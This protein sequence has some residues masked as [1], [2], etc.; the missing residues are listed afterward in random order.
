[1]DFRDIL[2]RFLNPGA[3]VTDKAIVS[4]FWA[5]GINVTDRALQLG[6]MLIVARVLGPEEL[7][8]FGIG[9]L[10]LTGLR[11]LSQLG[12]SEALIQRAEENIDYLL[13]SAWTLELLRG[14]VLGLLAVL[15][16]PLIGGLLHEPRAVPLIQSMGLLPL[17]QGMTNPAAIYFQKDLSFHKEFLFRVSGSVSNF[18]VSATFAII[19]ETVWA[20]IA[21]LVASE[22][23]RLTASYA[24]DGYR[25][26]LRINRR[27]FAELM[28]YGKWIF[29]SSGLLF[30]IKNG[31]DA[32]L[33]GLLGPTALGLYQLSYRISNA[34]AT[35][36]ANVFNKVFFPTY[37]KFQSD[38]TQLRRGYF[39]GLKLISLCAFPISGGII[40]IAPAFVTIALGGQWSDSIILIQILGFF[41]LLRALGATDGPLIRA[42]GRP[43]I[44]TK[45]HLLQFCILGLIIFPFTNRY[46]VVGAS[47]AVVLSILPINIGK[48]IAVL[49]LVDGT[50]GRYVW[51][52]L[53]PAIATG[54][55][56]IAVHTTISYLHP[57]GALL[58][59]VPLGII[60]YTG[61]IVALDS[62]VDYGVRS[63]ISRMGET[64]GSEAN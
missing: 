58:I 15:A 31:D 35:E 56:M 1:M 51:I 61:G 38:N 18:S 40:V 12:I 10:V 33:A 3:N 17:L 22:L 14:I 24:L 62:T 7:G 4:G 48:S 46:G 43:D 44:A 25:P 55:M 45:F 63:L 64:F 19:Y 32:V 34:P 13:D 11:G 8:L 53:I 20:L 37:S 52:L 9:L 60:C 36:V 23:V 29:G 42:I 26:S 6:S 21:G 50:I 27:E 41:G 59:G 49:R 30:F 39:S 2:A 54:L 28:D 57:I 5:T 47:I 16:G